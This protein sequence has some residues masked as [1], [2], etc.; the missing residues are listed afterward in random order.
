MADGFKKVVYWTGLVIGV[1]LVLAIV[2]AVNQHLKLT[3][4]A[5]VGA[6]LADVLKWT[7]E[8][9]GQAFSRL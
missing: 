8:L 7:G 9:F 5:A 1:L 4:M 2:G 3:S 6:G